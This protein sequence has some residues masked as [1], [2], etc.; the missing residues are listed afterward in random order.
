MA[1][2]WNQFLGKGAPETRRENPYNAVAQNAWSSPLFDQNKFAES[3]FSDS[4]YTPPD[5]KAGAQFGSNHEPQTWHNY[6]SPGSVRNEMLSGGMFGT[7][8]GSGP[9]DQQVFDEWSKRNTHAD[10]Y[11][12]DPAYA[13]QWD[14]EHG[15][16]STLGNIFNAAVGGVVLGGL[17]GQIMNPAA[18]PIATGP[19]VGAFPTPAA[20]GPG[21]GLGVVASPVTSA[22][23]ATTQLPD[24][25]YNPS[26]PLANPAGTFTGGVTDLPAIVPTP[27]S[28]VTGLEPV[29]DM[30]LGGGNMPNSMLNSGDGFDWMNLLIP[31]AGLASAYLSNQATG[32]AMDEIARQYDQTRADYEPWRQAGI[33]ALDRME[34]FDINRITTDPMYA[35]AVDEA[36]RAMDRRNSA[37]GYNLSSNWMNDAARTAANLSTDYGQR[38][39]DRDAT[40]AGF[41]REANAQ[42][43]MLGSNA[44]GNLANLTLQGGQG[45]NDS[46]QG[47]ISN[48]LTYQGMQNNPWAP[49]LR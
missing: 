41:G 33:G 46:I 16:G 5:Q 2:N 8:P 38:I 44:A 4:Q 13:A 35:A 9:T 34:N 28:G 48:W 20:T 3:W 47:T 1:V 6:W 30:N 21:A 49:Y 40:L 43:A 12:S 25:T 19:D 17:G 39:W 42:N 15:Q 45:L 7:G 18:N 37:A 31:G 26:N 14:A 27:G 23:T 36:M 10:R 29:T 24:A 22:P 32:D 11:R